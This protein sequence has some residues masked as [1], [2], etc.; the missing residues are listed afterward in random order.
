M[1][2]NAGNAKTFGIT[3]VGD[4]GKVTT[5]ASNDDGCPAGQYLAKY[6]SGSVCLNK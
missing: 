3:Y 4:G 5:M 6:S 2:L 1:L